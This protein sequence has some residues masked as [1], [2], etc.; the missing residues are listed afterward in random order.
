[1]GFRAWLLAAALLVD[2]TAQQ[3]AVVRITVTVVDADQK[4]M[5]VPRHAL[6]ISDN[7]ATAPPQRTM[8]ALDGTAEVHL[9]PGSYTIESD[10]PLVFQGKAYQWNR[11]IVVKAGVPASIEFTAAN[12]QVEATSL[13]ASPSSPGSTSGAPGSPAS[14]A[15]SFADTSTSGILM[16]WQN[17]VVSIWSPTKLGAGFLVDPRGL[18]ATNQR[19][20]GAA[21]T[22]EVQ[23]SPAEKIPARVL[24][25]D[26]LRNVAILW[27]DPKAVASARAVTLAYADGGA[28]PA[29]RDKVFAIGARV[30]A[31]KS[32]TGGLVSRTTAH[33]FLADIS[34]D[35]EAFGGP[36]FNA[37][38]GVIG[39]STPDEDLSSPSFGVR[40]VRIDELRTILAEAEKKMQNAV[41]PAATRLPVDPVRPFPAN[42]LKEAA[43]RRVG[44]LSPYHVAAADFEVN[45][46]TPVL[47][48]GA[49]HQSDRAGGGDRERSGRD[50]ASMQSPLRSVEDFANWSDYVRDDPPVLMIR[51]TPK[52][53]ES[54]WTTIARGAAQTQGVA[55]PPIKH[56]KAGF[57]RMRVT[58]GDAEVTPIHPFKLEQRVDESS[59]VYEGLYVFDPG[60]LGPQCGSVK[61]TL[62]SDKDPGKGDTRVVDPKIL[63]QIW[64]DFA[65][66]RA[67]SGA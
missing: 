46:L 50:P 62:F 20:V 7:P 47:V 25:S 34:L 54:F 43:E 3:L 33:T 48:Y 19:L 51:A 32:L 56:V 21:T 66:Y 5:P 37:A 45:L 44:N 16:D 2:V 38:G 11:T 27:V 63:Q 52:L 49:R 12:A 60:A 8:T 18:I 10:E 6:L 35:D 31:G 57:S 13:P 23:L 67:A 22:L 41:P 40:A 61:V 9:R 42:V 15:S 53:V 55:L 1:M 64:D 59:V 4:P 29:E 30:H 36:L 24:A 14:P 28:P 26:S 17:S 65:P 58:C 39:I